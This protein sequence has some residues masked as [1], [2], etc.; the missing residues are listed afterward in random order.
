MRTADVDLCVC[1]NT[2]IKKYA[3]ETM[4]MIK[5]MIDTFIFQTVILVNYFC[6]GNV[7]G[8]K[9]FGARGVPTAHLPKSRDSRAT[10]ARLLSRR[11]SSPLPRCCRWAAVRLRGLRDVGLLAQLA[12]SNTTRYQTIHHLIYHNLSIVIIF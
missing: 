7:R 11:C 3:M 2:I 12:S 5:Q 4:K 10:V 9:R 6:N 1:E 8:R